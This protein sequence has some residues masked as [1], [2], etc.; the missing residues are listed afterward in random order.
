MTGGIDHLSGLTE[1]QDDFLDVLGHADPGVRV[2]WCGRWRVRN[3][4]VHLGRIH[5]WAAAQARR[6]RE[7]P[8]G[9]G[10]FELAPFYA[11]QAAELR[12]TLAE[13]DPAQRAWTLLDDG[14]PPQER[15]G[16]VAFWHR[17]QALETLIH[18]WD[19]RTAI[20][21]A[22][23]AVSAAWWIDCLDEVATVMHPRQIRLAR[24]R[25]P[26]ATLIFRPSETGDPVPLTGAE[27]G[28]ATV[29]IEGPAR[30]LAL[31]AWGRADLD[32]PELSVHGPREAAAGVLAAGLSP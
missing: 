23:P 12:A 25:P 16:T 17:R 9:R 4:A 11:E 19:L 20:G 29:T 28:A 6:Q 8:L 30:T 24:I 13:L 27:N 32:A 5:H 10:P 21:D 31:L 2:P 26:S 22:E 1:F 14:V 7:T 15:S 18:L 3:L